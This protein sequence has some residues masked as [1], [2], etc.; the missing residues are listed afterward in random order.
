MGHQILNPQ[1]QGTASPKAL[2]SLNSP[3]CELS[4]HPFQL[5]RELWINTGICTVGLREVC[6]SPQC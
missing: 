1:H 4:C 6:G 3:V 2:R 5:D